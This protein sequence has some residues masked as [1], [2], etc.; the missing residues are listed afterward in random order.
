MMKKRLRFSLIAGFGCFIFLAVLISGCITTTP[1]TQ[2]SG[3][4]SVLPF[5]PS[6]PPTIVPTEQAPNQNQVALLMTTVQ[7]TVL[8]NQL[9]EPVTLRINRAEKQTQI[10]M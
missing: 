4:T 2:T 9:N 8:T 7:T 10:Y 5:Q 3:P 1:S 6:I